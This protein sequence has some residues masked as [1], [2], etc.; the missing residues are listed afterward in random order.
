MME[1]IGYIKDVIFAEIIMKKSDNLVTQSTQANNKE[2]ILINEKTLDLIREWIR[3]EID[4]KIVDNEEGSDGYYGSGYAERKIADS[5]F[6]DI[7][8]LKNLSK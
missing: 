6:E 5:L 7:K 1:I 4:A 3:A 2:E 8:N